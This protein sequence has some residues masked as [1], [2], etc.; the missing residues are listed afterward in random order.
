MKFKVNT[1]FTFVAIAS[2]FLCVTSCDKDDDPTPP[3]PTEDE[4]IYKKAENPLGQ[5]VRQWITEWQTFT[6]S[7]TCD[8]A[9]TLSAFTIPGQNQ[10]MLFLKGTELVDGNA[11]ITM[12]HGQSLFIPVVAAF[13]STPTCSHYT[14]QIQP[15]QDPQNFLAATVG[16]ILDGTREQF[17]KIDGT[18]VTNL[19]SYQYQT[20]MASLTPNSTLQNCSTVFKCFPE[21][22][23]QVMTK[24]YFVVI[25]P[26]A[27]GS[28]TITFHSKNILFDTQ[29]F[30]TLNITVI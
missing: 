26:L 30:S 1:L 10:L 11:N 22:N 28:H 13:Y 21:G 15:G 19:T 8:E 5:T 25:K 14:Y 27:I 16:A 23:L 3:T 2:L 6:L 20:D 12:E 7:Q 24:G 17:I 29:F 4:R 9:K 18:D